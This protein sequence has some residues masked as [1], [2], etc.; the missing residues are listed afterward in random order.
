MRRRLSDVFE[1]QSSQESAGKKKQLERYPVN[2]ENCR[3][4]EERVNNFL[5]TLGEGVMA[6]VKVIDASHPLDPK[7]QSI[8]IVLTNPQSGKEARLTLD[9]YSPEFLLEDTLKRIYASTTK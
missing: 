2:I 1:A 9:E 3:K 4:V 7:L 5:P 8:S 6:S